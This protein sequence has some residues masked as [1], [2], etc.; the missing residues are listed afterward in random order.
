MRRIVRRLREAFR[1]VVA[2][3]RKK[4]HAKVS[5][6]YSAAKTKPKVMM[7]KSVE[8]NVNESKFYIP[9]RVEEIKQPQPDYCELPSGYGQDRIVL[10]VRDPWWIHAYWE[11][12][13]PTWRELRQRFPKEFSR[14]FKKILRV[15]DIS[16]IIFTGGNANRFFDIEISAEANNWYIDTQEPGRSWCV[17]LGLLFED[18]RFVTIVRSNTVATPPAGPSW[19]T[20]EEWMIPQDIFTRLYGMGVGMGSS[21]LKLRELWL[22]RLRNEFGSGAVSSLASPVIKKE[23]LK[24]FQLVVNT[25]LIIY[26]QTEPQARLTVGG[27]PIELRPD[28][29]FSL[30]F[31]LPDGKQVIPVVAVSSDGEQAKSIT[32]IIHKETK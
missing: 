6:I 29:S 27:Q 14:G 4:T 2:R 3:R 13:E 11:I 15:Y 30:R 25:E 5:R 12:T 26:G 21:P 19:I 18:G 22:E 24:D 32:P 17:D 16:N 9:P 1:K 10:Q 31:F 8:V 23:R 28:G 7:R 20:D